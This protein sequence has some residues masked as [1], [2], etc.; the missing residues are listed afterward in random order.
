MTLFP[1]INDARR[2]PPGHGC[3]LALQGGAAHGA[4]TWG[5]VDRLLE[6]GKRFDSICGVSAG[7]MLGAVL[8]QGMVENGNTGARAAMRRLWEEVSAIGAIGP[9]QRSPL[10]RFL[11]GSDLS[12]NVMWAGLETAMRLFSPHQL[13]PLGH[14]PLRPLMQ[15]LL[16]PDLLAAPEAPRL[17]VGVTDVE[18]GAPVIFR[19]AAITVEVLLASACL[20][21]VFPA[22]EIDGR[23]YWDGGYSGNPPLE[24]LLSPLPHTLFLVRGQPARRPGVPRTPAEIMNRLNEIA[25]HAVLET[26]LNALPPSIA[27]ITIDADPALG[28]LPISSKFNTDRSFLAE[29]FEEGQR[30]AERALEQTDLQTEP[31]PA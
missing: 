1:P 30:A 18:T 13:N 17:F 27:V 8:V 22:V 9:L 4:F 10:E 21:L 2:P 7:A 12:S 11:Y 3:A 23:A 29:L 16:R 25:C 5:A 28:T 19:N 14:N 31:L 6:A 26:E 15:D 20:P 24:P